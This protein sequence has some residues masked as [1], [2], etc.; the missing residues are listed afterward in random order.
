MY[1][2]GMDM[3]TYVFVY[4]PLYV[5]SY[6][7]VYVYGVHTFTRIY[8]LVCTCACVCAQVYSSMCMCV[9]HGLWLSLG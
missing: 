7:T 9:A 6:N 8:A 4:I 3:C 1:S 2:A 5:C